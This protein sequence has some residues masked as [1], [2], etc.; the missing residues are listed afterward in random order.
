MTSQLAAVYLA[1]KEFAEPLLARLSSLEDL[2]YLFYRHGWRV[3]LDDAAFARISEALAVTTATERFLAIAGPLRDRLDSQ[4]DA[5]LSS[6]E[7]SAVADAGAA[8]IEAIATFGMPSLDGLPSPL[9][10]ADTW[11]NVAKQLFDDLLEEYLRVYHQGVYAVLSAIGCIQDQSADPS[12]P[13][14]VPYTRSV[15]DWSQ[16]VAFIEDPPKALKTV[17]RWG[18]A[19]HPFD[20]ARLVDA[21]VRVLRVVGLPAQRFPASLLSAPL[22]ANSPYRIQDDVDALRT[23]ITYGVLREQKAVLETGVELLPAAAAGEPAASGIVLRPVIR[24]SG[25]GSVPIGR[26]LALKWKTAADAGG[27]I[28]V[29]IFPDKTDLVTGPLAIG[30]SI[31]LARTDP[32]PWYIVGSSHTSRIEVRNPSIRF[33]IAGAADDPEARLEVSAPGANGVPGARL[34]VPLGDADSFIKES[35]GQS[36]IDRLVFAGRRLVEPQRAGVQRH[37]QAPGRRA[38]RRLD[39]S[40]SGPPPAPPAVVRAKRRSPGARARSVSRRRSVARTCDRNG[41]PDRHAVRLRFRE[42][43]C[44][45]RIRGRVDRLQAAVRHRAHGGGDRRQRRRI[46]LPRS[47]QGPVRRRRPAESRRRHHRHRDRPHHDAP[48][49]RRARASRSSIIITAEDFRPIPLGLGF[50]ADGHRRPRRR[51]SHVQR[52]RSCARG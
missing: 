30:A 48:A 42:D 24:A 3:G 31:E 1:L 27:A 16:A 35:V 11:A 6:E 49:E 20:H 36:A 4:P 2:E 40:R 15:F 9:D 18:D 5:S 38:G 21:L 22:A 26:G 34:V 47:R 19:A 29:A 8:L 12:G 32:D 50:I 52:G 51:Q 17:Y 28:G 46:P 44:E 23:T 33:S 14:R 43:A 37:A 10:K 41:R 25:E 45:L 13:Y 39:R 7:M